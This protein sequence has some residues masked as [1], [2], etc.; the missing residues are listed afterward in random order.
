M[1]L[2]YRTGDWVAVLL[3]R[4]AGY[5]PPRVRI[6]M[7]VAPHMDH[8][9]TLRRWRDPDHTGLETVVVNETAIYG[10]ADPPP[11]PYEDYSDSD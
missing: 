7:V 2:R 1:S 3:S 8:T 6:M 9:Y 5:H 4:D 11:T 10:L